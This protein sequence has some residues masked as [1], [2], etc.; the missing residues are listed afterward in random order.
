MNEV[1][2]EDRYGIMHSAGAAPSFREVKADLWTVCAEAEVEPARTLR[3]ITTNGH[4]NRAGRCVMGRGCA[5][6]ARDKFPGLDRKLGRLIAE[7]GNRPMRLMKLPDGSHLGSF[8]VKHHWREDA[9]PDLIEASARMLVEIA[10]RFG[11]ERIFLPRPG[12]GNGRLSWPSV[13]A[14]IEPILDERFTVV[15][16]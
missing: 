14:R 7:H 12:C 4:I 2:E 10:D 9:D 6:E 5:L 8:P 11:Y 13:R 16:F 15:S 3:L 1:D